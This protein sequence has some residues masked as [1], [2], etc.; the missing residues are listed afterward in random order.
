[1]TENHESM[2]WPP[3]SVS[4]RRGNIIFVSGMVP[5]DHDSGEVIGR[6]VGE[7]TE[8]VLQLLREELVAQGASMA[9][10]VKTTVLLADAQRDWSAMNDVYRTHFPDPKPARS[11]FGVQLATPGML[12]EIEAVAVVNEAE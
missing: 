8:V 5:I 12:V 7:Q 9:D 3:L 4:Y 10:V 11:A 2:E 1:M 6:T